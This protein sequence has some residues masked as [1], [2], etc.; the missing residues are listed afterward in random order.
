MEERNGQ[1]G[2]RGLYSHSGGEGAPRPSRHA[3]LFGVIHRSQPR[4]HTF[5][6]ECGSH[7]SSVVRAMSTAQPMEYLVAVV[8]AD[9]N[10]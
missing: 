1:R 9:I 10:I 6:V 3:K 5:L 4:G 8:G 2:E 7:S